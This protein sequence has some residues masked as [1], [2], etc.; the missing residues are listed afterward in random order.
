[1][2]DKLFWKTNKKQTMA[3]FIV[4]CLKITA[5]NNICVSA[6]VCHKDNEDVAKTMGFEVI[7]AQLNIN[8]IIIRGE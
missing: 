8:A 6:I 4:E 5:E 1:M 2:T 3:D 7:V